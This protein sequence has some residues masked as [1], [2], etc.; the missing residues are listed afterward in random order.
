MKNICYTSREA[1]AGMRN[2]S[3]SPP[4][5]NTLTTE[6]HLAPPISDG[7]TNLDDVQHAVCPVYTVVH[8]VKVH[9]GHVIQA[10][11]YE[12]FESVV[13]KINTG[14]W[15]L[16]RK[17]NELSS[18][19]KWKNR[20][21]L[22]DVLLIH[23]TMVQRNEGRKTHSTHF[24]ARCS[25]VVRAFTYGAIGRRIDP[26]RWT[27]WAISRSSQCSTTGVTKA[28]VCY[29]VYGIMHI[30]EPLLLIGKSSPYDGSWFLLSLSE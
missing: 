16:S 10:L 6:L 24:G 4:W 25:S 14:N 22:T 23:Y 13:V 17:Q 26:L 19:W 15:G 30:K 5:A 8:I 18:F 7:A 28:V 11:I 21:M 20:I 1:L 27:H 12:H 29:P 9:I 3:M 2:S